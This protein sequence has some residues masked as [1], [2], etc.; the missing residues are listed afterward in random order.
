M[1]Q[2]LLDN[3][4]STRSGVLTAVSENILIRLDDFG[5]YEY[6]ALGPLS[7]DEVEKVTALDGLRNADEDEISYALYGS[8]EGVKKDPILGHYLALYCGAVKEGEFR[9]NGTSGGITTWLLTELLNN[10]DIDG[11]VAVVNSQNGGPLYQYAILRTREEVASSAKSRYYPME[12]SSVLAAIKATPGRYAVVGIPSFISDLRRLQAID[13]TFR[14]RIRFTFS[15]LCG[16]QKTTKYGEAIGFEAGFQPDQIRSIDFRYKTENS[17]ASEYVTEIVGCQSGK[18]VRVVV[19][20]KSA[21]VNDWSAGM[22]K[23][24]FS[25]FVDDCFGET[26]DIS[27]GDAWL[28]QYASDGRGTNVVVVRD[29]H[30]RAIL[31]RA[32]EEGRLWL[33]KVDASTVKD[34]Q[35]GLIRHYRTELPYRLAK[36]DGVGLKKRVQPSLQLPYLRR[37]VQDLRLKIA[38]VSKRQYQLAV[39]KSD[40]TY[41]KRKMDPLMWRYHMIYKLLRLRSL[42]FSGTIRI[43]L[44]RR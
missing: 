25:D 40:W 42:G 39:E 15:L 31:D 21:F 2:R 3:E 10:G 22:F 1:M 20:G 32:A 29:P 5:Q 9:A 38:V 33:D 6:H 17:V 4:F 35:P 11:V 30:I 44:S 7:H 34:S 36:Y 19:P 43:L 14:E 18:M 23:V 27:L 8:T 28:P 12:L 37:L 16:H 24:N 41:F 13:E 26:A